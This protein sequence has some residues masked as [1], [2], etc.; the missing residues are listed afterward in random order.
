MLAAAVVPLSSAYAIAEAVGV[1]RSVSSNFREAPLFLGL[2]SAQV[3]IGAAIALAPGNLI[4]LLINTQI[5]NG[6]VCPVFLTF[7]LVLANR[8]S[9]LGEAAN[10]PWFRVLATICVGGVG[11]LA[12]LVVG[13]TVAGWF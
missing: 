9:V 2:F 11:T 3:L 5:I 1:E 4:N 10:K 6:I 13:I 12:V 7:I 8:R